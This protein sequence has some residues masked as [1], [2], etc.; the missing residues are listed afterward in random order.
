MTTKDT[1][2]G[3]LEEKLL[4]LGELCREG[5]IDPDFY[6]HA[7]SFEIDKAVV[8]KIQTNYLIDSDSD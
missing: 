3:T 7:R 5:D 6:T 8:E 2:E 4:F 1:F